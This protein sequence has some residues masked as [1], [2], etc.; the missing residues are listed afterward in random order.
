[1]PVAAV[2]EEALGEQVPGPVYQKLI[3]AWNDLVGL[4]IIEQIR[5]GAEERIRQI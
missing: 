3:A 2:N 1:M 5:Q 4:D